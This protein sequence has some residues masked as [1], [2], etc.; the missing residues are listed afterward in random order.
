M[1]GC[2]IRYLEKTDTCSL[3]SDQQ[4][5]K[6]FLFPQGRPPRLLE[7]TGSNFFEEEDLTLQCTTQYAR[8]AGT[9]VISPLWSFVGNRFVIYIVL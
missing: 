1:N 4:I 8:N 7:I 5:T 2:G 3:V 6:P 9:R